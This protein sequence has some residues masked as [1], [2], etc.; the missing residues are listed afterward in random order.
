M[1]WWIWVLVGLAMLVMEI[2]TPGGFFILFFGVGAL[3]VGALAGA[4]LVE[5]EWLQWLLFSVV[6]V[7]SLVLFRKRLL[8][9]FRGPE[10]MA[11]RAPTGVGEIATLTEDLPP[12]AVGRAELRGTTWTTRSRATTALARGQRCRVMEVDGLTLWV[13]PE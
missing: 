11:P 13:E 2:L 4:G 8:A 1:E 6:S 9:R 3:V 5:S 7:A 12:G 10:A